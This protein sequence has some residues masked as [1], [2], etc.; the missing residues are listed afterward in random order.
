MP[1]KKRNVLLAITTT[2]HGLYRGVARFAREH[3]WHLTTDMLYAATIPYGWKGDG[4][5]SHV[6]YWSELAD[7]IKS[8]TGPK[9]ELTSVRRDLRIPYVEGDNRA[10]GEIAAHHFLSRGYRNFAWF[11]FT[12]DAINDERRDG[13]VE[14]I[15]SKGF[16]CKPLPPLHELK[17]Y[18]WKGNWPKN[19]AKISAAIAALPKPVAIFCYN[20]CAAANVLNACQELGIPVPEQ[21]AI[22]GV[23]NDEL[24]C[25]AVTV[26]LTSV[27]HDLEGVG[28]QGAALL[29]RIMN[30]EKVSFEVPRIRPQGITLRQS[31]DM[32]AVNNFEV[33]RA[34]RYIWDHFSDSRL[35]VTEVVANTKLSR[36]PLE[37]LFKKEV[38]RTI[39]QEITRYRLEKARALLHHSSRSASEISQ[40]CGFTRP[41]QLHR[42]FKKNI[43]LSPGEFKKEQEAAAGPP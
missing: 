34:L 15:A 25:E 9:V 37:I 32:L 41:N 12:N 7:F 1:K 28:Y 19:I 13:F 40:V 22:V 38:G 4:I 23:D 6:G 36:R 18:Q 26:P 3:N 17:H 31:S 20:D 21:V 5:I 11:P 33:A 29:E 27:K 16:H 10:I 30:G 8:A 14:A 43:G 24:L 39:N 42:V 2:H 35:Q